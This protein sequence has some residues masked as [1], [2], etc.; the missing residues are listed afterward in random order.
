VSPGDDDKTIVKIRT[1]PLC[2]TKPHHAGT[3]WTCC[4]HFGFGR[5][6]FIPYTPND[7]YSYEGVEMNLRS[8]GVGLVLLAAASASQ[9]VYTININ[10]VGPDVVM[11]GSGSINTSSFSS[12]GLIGPCLLGDGFIG[13]NALCVG[14]DTNGDWYPGAL[15]PGISL[16]SVVPTA[17]SSSLGP[18]VFLLGT[19]LY[20]P[21]NY[22]SASL[23]ANQTTFAGTTLAAIGLNVGTQTLFVPSGDEIIINVGLAPPAAPASIPTLGEYALLG[24]SSLLAM[25]G[26]VAMRRKRG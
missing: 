4:C 26:M 24:L 14:S 8:I 20:L 16:P 9:A 10:Q 15:S 6:K 22:I 21:A 13:T 25:L 19:E 23:I 1:L 12:V 7:T 17:G 2:R 5:I 3:H 18:N 11:S